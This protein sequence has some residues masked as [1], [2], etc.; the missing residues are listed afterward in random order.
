MLLPKHRM[1]CLDPVLRMADGGDEL[2]FHALLLLFLR[3][4]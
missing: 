3:N 1:T 4:R 2:L